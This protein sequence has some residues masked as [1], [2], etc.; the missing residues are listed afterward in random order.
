MR[1]TNF[2]DLTPRGRTITDCGGRQTA[3]EAR[4]RA[5]D[6]CVTYLETEVQAVARAAS[7]ELEAWLKTVRT[8]EAARAVLRELQEPDWYDETLRS[9]KL[10]IQIKIYARWFPRHYINERTS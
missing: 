5:F 6:N 4:G 8:K 3:A 2:P 7:A 1:E 10:T 9:M